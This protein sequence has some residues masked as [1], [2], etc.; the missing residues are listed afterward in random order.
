MEEQLSSD[1]AEHPGSPPSAQTYETVSQ[2]YV[3]LTPLLKP[4]LRPKREIDK[5]NR[6]GGAPASLMAM[7]R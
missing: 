6:P 4:T 7:V 3:D 5:P 1:A 2:H